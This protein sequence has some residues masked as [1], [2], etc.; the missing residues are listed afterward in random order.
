LDLPKKPV[1]VEEKVDVKKASG[2]ESDWP[3]DN[4]PPGLYAPDGIPYPNIRA[5]VLGPLNPFS[6]L[7][8]NPDGTVSFPDG[9]IV[10]APNTWVML[11][12]DVS[13]DFTEELTMAEQEQHDL[14][15]LNAKNEEVFRLK[16]ESR[17]NAFIQRKTTN[18]EAE[19]AKDKFTKSFNPYTGLYTDQITGKQEFADG[20]EVEGS[21]EWVGIASS[22][23]HHHY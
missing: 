2:N 4:F 13:N 18:R 12:D 22:N 3:I 9:T 19:D 17:L 1:K 15:L 20:E 5:K 14:E 21:N 23:L 6:G 16:R 11:G 10:D 7:L 8:N